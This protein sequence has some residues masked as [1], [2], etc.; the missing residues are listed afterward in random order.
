MDFCA[1]SILITSGETLVCTSFANL[2]IKE[3]NYANDENNGCDTQMPKTLT[4]IS[5]IFDTF[6][7]SDFEDRIIDRI[8]SYGNVQAIM[9]RDSQIEPGLQLVDNMRSILRLHK[10][11]S[12]KYGFYPMIEKWVREV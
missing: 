5:I 3:Q 9:A 12:D 7:K 11:D 4:Q 2:T 6:N 8:S 1:W 10:S